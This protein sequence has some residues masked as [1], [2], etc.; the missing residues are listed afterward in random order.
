[1]A[2]IRSVPESFLCTACGG[3]AAVC[4]VDAIEMAENGAGFL[5]ARVSDACVDCGLCRDVC[6]SLPENT[7]AFAPA[8]L[9]H[10]DVLAGFA[11]H[12]VAEDTRLNGQS[13]GVVT[14][15]LAFALDSG[16][17]DGAVVNGFDP[18]RRRPKA[19][20][21]RSREEVLAS[22][23]SYYTQSAVLPVLREKQGRLAAVTLGCQSEAVTML[24]SVRP[25]LAPEYLIGL[26]CAGQNSGHMIDDICV[27]EGVE[28]PTAFRFR[29]KRS[30]GW[31]GNITVA[32]GGETRTV[33]NAYRHQI[34]PLYECHRCLTCF[35]QMNAGADIVCGDPWGIGGKDG[36]E[37]W[38]VIL[39]R[40]EKG[41]DLLQAAEKAGV[42]HLEPLDPAEIFR[43]QT[44]EDRHRDKVY[45]AK[46]VFMEKGWPYPYDPGVVGEE[47]PTPKSLQ[48]TRE[49]LVYTR[50]YASAPTPPAAQRIAERKRNEKPPLSVR[51]KKWMKKR[52]KKGS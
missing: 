4:P 51:L 23:G 43:G 37:G 39:A 25:E 52:R 1:M 6:P 31:P 22:A 9:L 24:R 29:D 49:K 11:G 50:T 27:H 10:G 41:L 20:I 36:P 46:Q 48:R 40:T 8:D 28:Q 19:F 38:S 32:T 44:V 14:A 13:G 26:V 42:L 3:C 33:P 7:A 21:A 12:A 35:D 17:I 45:G 34:K 16:L 15:L 5:T 18:E 2:N 47:T 30:G